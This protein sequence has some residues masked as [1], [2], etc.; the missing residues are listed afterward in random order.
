MLSLAHAFPYSG[1]ESLSVGFWK[2]NE[3]AG[4]QITEIF[5]QKLTEGKDIASALGEA[6]MYYLR[7]AN[8]KALSPEFWAG[9]ILIDDNSPIYLETIIS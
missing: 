2:I 9:I 1:S 8:R 5:Y 4:S 6:K 7:Y 3:K